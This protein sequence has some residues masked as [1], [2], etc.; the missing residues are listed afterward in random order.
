MSPHG[1]VV[2]AE[3]GEGV[4]HLL[5]VAADGTAYVLARNDLND[6]E[7]AGPTFS[8]DGRTLFVG[9]QTPGHVLAITGPWDRQPA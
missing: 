8:P 2:A 3:D 4:Q 7:F 5:G 6:N 1:G 9:I